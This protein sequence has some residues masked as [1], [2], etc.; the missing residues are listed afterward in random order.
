MFHMR[1]GTSSG[2]HVTSY[3]WQGHIYVTYFWWQ[4]LKDPKE[5]DV[6][7]YSRDMGALQSSIS[8]PLAPRDGAREGPRQPTRFV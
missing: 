2:V 3:W 6:S 5:D 4:G 8:S 7:T 1:W